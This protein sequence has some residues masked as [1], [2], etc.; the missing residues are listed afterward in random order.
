MEE[1]TQIGSELDIPLADPK[2]L[3]DGKK[4]DGELVAIDTV[5]KIEVDSHYINGVYDEDKTVR[6]QV[7]EIETVVLETIETAEGP[8]DIRVNARFNLK[9]IDGVWSISKHPKA[10]L[11]KFMRKMGVEK[12]ADLKGMKVRLTLEPS[13]NPD[14]DRSYLRIIK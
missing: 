14:D 13:S 5:K 7:I 12:V 9:N 6:V 2:P 1:N 3:F 11:Y 8:K 4:Y 10:A